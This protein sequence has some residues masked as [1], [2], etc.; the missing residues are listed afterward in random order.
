MYRKYDTTDTT[1]IIV[2]FIGFCQSGCVHLGLNGMVCSC[3]N[4][5]LLAAFQK[6][7]VIS[8]DSCQIT[9]VSCHFLP[10]FLSDTPQ[11]VAGLAKNI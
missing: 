5:S 2:V 7:I 4:L 9:N 1:D 6:G 10:D 8:F 11:S 3:G